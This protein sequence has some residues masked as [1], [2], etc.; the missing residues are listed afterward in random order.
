MVFFFYMIIVSNVRLL[1]L[2]KC[3][4]YNLKSYKTY[5]QKCLT[6][7]FLLLSKHFTAS[8]LL[9]KNTFQMYATSK[10][11]LYGY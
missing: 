2:K 1:F 6:I 4:I 8:S 11:S 10:Q 5:H 3:I 7:D 9:T